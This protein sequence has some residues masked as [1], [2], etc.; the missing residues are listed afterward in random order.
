MFQDVKSPFAIWGANPTTV[1]APS[2]WG[3]CKGV[4]L[5]GEDFSVLYAGCGDDE[6]GGA[7]CGV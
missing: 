7:D 2:K 6:E 1:D 4:R 3:F 5:D